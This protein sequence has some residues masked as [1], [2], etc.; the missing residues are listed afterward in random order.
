M[1]DTAT[2][3]LVV[4]DETT[5]HQPDCVHPVLKKPVRIEALVDKVRE[6]L[7]LS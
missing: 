3:V 1:T 4:D 6:V 7:A 5:D 2:Q